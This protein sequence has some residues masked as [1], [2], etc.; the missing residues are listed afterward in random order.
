MNRE[1]QCQFLCCVI[2]KGC[3]EN[4]QK[5]YANQV[6]P[7]TSGLRKTLPAAYIS[8]RNLFFWEIIVFSAQVQTF[9]IIPRPVRNKF[10]ITEMHPTPKRPRYR[11]GF[12][13]DWTTFHT[14]SWLIGLE[15]FTA[16][17]KLPDQ[18]WLYII[19][20]LFSSFGAT[21]ELGFS[22]LTRHELAII[23]GSA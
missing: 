19:S 8:F 16:A 11:F 10:L 4:R 15:I 21:V 2:M 20:V 12:V 9:P 14:N 5:C 7:L 22:R 23:V 1:I 13:S 17:K 3:N 18:Y 6:E